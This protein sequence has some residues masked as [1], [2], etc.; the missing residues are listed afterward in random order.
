MT[1]DQHDASPWSPYPES[2]A[3]QATAQPGAQATAEKARRKATRPWFKKKR[4]DLPL[5]VIAIISV[6]LAVNT[7]SNTGAVT[8]PPKAKAMAA[9][10]GTTVRDGSFEFVVTGVERPGK[11]FDGKY[12]K[13]L[14]ALGEFVIVRVNVTNVG[15][16]DKRLGCSCQ[17][18]FNEKGQKL[19]PSPEILSTKDAL[20]YV[21]WI[22]PGDTVTG[23]SVLFDVVPGTKA[24]N[25]ELHDSASS[26]G[27][28]VDLS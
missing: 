15:D 26:Q 6:I 2:A 13:T 27:V 18:L 3:G 4:F 14:M 7:R 12:G 8:S 9:E 21:E 5:A 22:S 24:L 16:K 10:I 1:E 17:F 25:I 20:K 28:K 19:S 11:S 23:A